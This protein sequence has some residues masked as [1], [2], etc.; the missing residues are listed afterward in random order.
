VST[1]DGPG[2]PSQRETPQQDTPEPQTQR[3]DTPEQGVADAEPTLQRDESA[4]RKAPARRRAKGGRRS[5]WIELPVLLVVA[6]VL[7]MVLKTWVVEA[8]WIP[9][10]SMQNTLAINDRIL[11]N[12]LVYD[13]RPIARGDIVVFNGDGSWNPAPQTQPGLFTR[14]VDDIRTLGGASEGGDIYIKRVIGVPGDHVVCCNSTGQITV[15][16]VALSE[17][18]YLYPDNAPSTTQ[19]SITVPPGRLWVMGDH[20][21]ISADSRFHLT[22]PGSGTIPENQVLGRAF[23]I[24]WPVSQWGFLNIP[25]TFSQAKLHS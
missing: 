10:G 11:I 18:S 16:G 3:Q 15:N 9:S 4:P 24:I 8:F 19:F 2:S 7:A 21:D 25:G 20:R 1:Q 22:E 12:K 6:L 5:F 23:V 13:F 17:S 14:I